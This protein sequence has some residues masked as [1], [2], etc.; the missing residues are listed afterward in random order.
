V[1][2]GL[3]IWECTF[4]LGQYILENKIELKNKLVMDLGCGAGLIG[5][6]SLRKNAAVHF[7]DYVR[8][9]RDCRA[10]KRPAINEIIFCRMPKC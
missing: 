1:Q 4:D 10:E 8:M 7:Q 9:I 6:L 2:G 3:K 5:L